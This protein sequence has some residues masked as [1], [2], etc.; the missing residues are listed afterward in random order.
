MAYG[1]K[2]PY[3]VGFK[4]AVKTSEIIPPGRRMSFITGF[5]KVVGKTSWYFPKISLFTPE[6]NASECINATV[7]Y[8]V[9]VSTQAPE[10][11]FIGG[12]PGIKVIAGKMQSLDV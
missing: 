1:I 9:F 5:R 8:T 4:Q 11:E 7:N 10:P 6:Q 2:S 3:V 12:I